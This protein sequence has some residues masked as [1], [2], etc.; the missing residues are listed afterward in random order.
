MFSGKFIVGLSCF[1]FSIVGISK[2]SEA[3]LS[4]A[5]TWCVN[6]ENASADL[7][8]G[9]CTS[10]IQSGK[11]TPANL[12]VAFTNRGNAHL[13]KKDSNAAI[14][15]YGEAIRLNPRYVHAHHNRGLAYAAIEIHHLAVTNYDEAIKLDPNFTSAFFNRGIAYVKLRDYD[16]AATDIVQANQLDPKSSNY[17]KLLKVIYKFLSRPAE[18]TSIYERA[19]AAREKSLGSDNLEIAENL[20]D[21]ARVYQH[22]GRYS[23]SL[24]FWER[25]LEIYNKKGP[26][27]DR[28]KWLITTVEE[29][30]D[31]A[32]R[33][34]TCNPVYSSA[35]TFLKT[36]GQSTSI[37]N[38]AAQE[39]LNL[40]ERDACPQKTQIF[41][42]SVT[43][44]IQCPVNGVKF[45]LLDDGSKLILSSEAN[46]FGHGSPQK[47]NEFLIGI[48]DEAFYCITT[49]HPKLT[50][51]TGMK[52]SALVRRDYNNGDAEFARTIRAR[53]KS[54]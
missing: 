47:L 35:L 10:V 28:R 4:Q 20:I 48:V 30:R 15:D 37:Y 27:E 18:A 25:A 38:A 31:F 19:L 2:T 3:Q 16:R 1:I 11:E 44:I 23:Q 22:L 41:A 34:P 54:R 17:F 12:A 6:K 36:A 52:V 21:L 26:N 40:G 13:R 39:L 7:Q 43:E 50:L 14:S 45:L 29:A 46:D 24:P 32:K 42:G 49:V 8:I 33:T 9:G 51:Y 5:W 53:K